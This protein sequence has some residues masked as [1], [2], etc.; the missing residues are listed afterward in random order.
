MVLHFGLV[1]PTMVRDPGTQ[2]VK[3]S[4]FAYR[5]NL[6]PCVIYGGA[7]VGE[8]IRNLQRG[9][10]LL[11][12]TPGRLVD[13]LERGKVGL[14]FCRFL[15]LDEADRMLDMGFEVNKLNQGS[16]DLNLISISAPNP[17]YHRTRFAPS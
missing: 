17:S 5:S 4:K 8:Q 1:I 12:A 9:C 6:K 10:H 7:D 2:L 14:E 16:M 11:V 3:P 15:C 13:F